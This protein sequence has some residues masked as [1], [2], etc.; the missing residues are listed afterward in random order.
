MT[1]TPGRN[2]AITGI[3]CIAFFSLLS[4]IIES[5]GKE[6]VIILIPMIS[7]ISTDIIAAGLIHILFLSPSTTMT[8]YSAK[9]IIGGLATAIG[10]IVYQWVTWTGTHHG[11]IMFKMVCVSIILSLIFYTDMIRS[12]GEYTNGVIMIVN[13]HLAVSVITSVFLPGPINVLI[14]MVIIVSLIAFIPGMMKTR[15]L[16]I[17]L[18]VI[19]NAIISIIVGCED[20]AK[21]GMVRSTLTITIMF[22]YLILFAMAVIPDEHEKGEAGETSKLKIEDDD[23]QLKVVV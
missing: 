22:S 15:Y 11:T 19:A 21:T 1:I 4:M 14:P 2:L 13:F 5:V 6:I 18:S 20:I 16:M 23:I 9:L 10:V 12:S 3:H 8:L 17:N 7:M